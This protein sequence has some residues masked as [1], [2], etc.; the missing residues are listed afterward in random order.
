MH[1]SRQVQKIEERG[2]MQ[3]P[4]IFSLTSFPC[5]IQRSTPTF[6]SFSIL[7]TTTLS[8]RQSNAIS[9]IATSSAY[10]RIQMT[11][12][13][14][15]PLESHQLCGAS[16]LPM[17]RPLPGN[18]LRGASYHTTMQWGSMVEWILSSRR[19]SYPSK[20]LSKSPNR[21]AASQREQWSLRT[22]KTCLTASHER[23]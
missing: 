17:L 2:Q 14:Y 16:S 10:I 12:Q 18:G 6:A 15:G 13:S 8:Q 21:K 7:Y 19:F 11:R 22:S 3:T 20:N 9:G 5:I 4:S 23:A 1:P